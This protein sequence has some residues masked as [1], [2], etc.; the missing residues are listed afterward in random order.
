MAL[1]AGSGGLIDEALVT[2]FP[3]PNSFSGQ[4]TVEISLHGGVAIVEA[5]LKAALATGLCR[6][7]GPG[8]FTRRAFEAGR[9]DL[10]RAEA[11][12]DMIDAETEA[13]RLQALEQFSGALERAYEGWRGQLIEALAALEVAVDF[14]D[15]ADVPVDADHGAYRALA[16]LE[17][18]L[19][20]VL[21][22]ARRGEGVREGFS[23]AIIG[24]PNAGKSSLINVLAKREAAIVSDIPGTTRD[25]VEVRLVLNGYITWIADTAGLRESADQV[26]AEGVRRA[27]ARA[28]SADLRLGVCDASGSVPDDLL[29][30][31]KPGDILV[32]N[33]TDL[34]QSDAPGVGSDTRHGLETIG[35]SALTR[36]GVDDLMARLGAIV[37]A[38]LSTQEPAYITRKRH[39]DLLEKAHDHIR[40]ARVSIALGPELAAED[41]RLAA[42]ALGQVTGKVDVEEILGAIFS[43]F[44][45]GK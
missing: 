6:L 8:E 35:V 40:R 27:L 9:L 29:E 22:S 39:R 41:V 32:L 21:A 25:V 17:A 24:K 44:C 5:C 33:K 43:R 31:M 12:A 23:I 11:I 20:T 37:S 18:E 30:A 4:D 1:R 15:E 36:E 3:A 16:S 10:T 28:G 45:I 19:E 7:A 26:E 42:R 14:S 38:R 13:Q 2:T 34:V